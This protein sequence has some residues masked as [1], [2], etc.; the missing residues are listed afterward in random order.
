LNIQKIY[1]NSFIILVRTDTGEYLR[2]FEFFNPDPSEWSADPTNAM[3][4]NQF[5]YAESNFRLIIERMGDP[6]NRSLR[7]KMSHVTVDADDLI[8]GKPEPLSVV[9]VS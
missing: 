4:F 6:L 9:K 3:R 5:D 8:V 2:K 7:I 1:S